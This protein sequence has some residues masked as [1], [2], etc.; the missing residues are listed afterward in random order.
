MGLERTL[1]K[2]GQCCMSFLDAPRIL[3]ISKVSEGVRLE[4]NGPVKAKKIV[5]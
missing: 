4:M 5:I 1:T 3:K 2:M